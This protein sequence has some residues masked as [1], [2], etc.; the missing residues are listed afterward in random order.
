MRFAHEV[1]G[2][3]APASLPHAPKKGSAVACSDMPTLGHAADALARGLRGLV[4]RDGSARIAVIAQDA[5]SAGNWAEVLG[6]VVPV[7]LVTRG[8][9]SFRP[10]V[11][12][13]DVTQVKGLEFDYVIAPDVSAERY[14]D[15]PL[16]RRMLH[17]LAT[18]A[19]HELW[20]VTLG[21]PSP[22]LPAPI[23]EVMDDR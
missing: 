8:E 19:I 22:I 1:L 2:S 15:T 21:A 18:R 12:V 17:V 23:S 4:D 20:V 10:G 7:R 11:D 9:F 16:S 5:D 14:P 6:W 13:T 3:Q